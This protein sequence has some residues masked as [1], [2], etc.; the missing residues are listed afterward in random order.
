LSLASA[1][2]LGCA[3]DPIERTNEE[4]TPSADTT[5]QARAQ[6]QSPTTLG[7]GVT[8]YTVAGQQYQAPAVLRLQADPDGRITLSA[9][10]LQGSRMMSLRALLPTSA[11]KAAGTRIALRSEVG[12]DTQLMIIEGTLPDV[13]VLMSIDGTLNIVRLSEKAVQLDFDAGLSARPDG[14]TERLVS[15]GTLSGSLQIVCMQYAG[16]DSNGGIEKGEGQLI[17]SDD[18]RTSPQCQSMLKLLDPS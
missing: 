14:T 1:L 18:A 4:T 16:P 6:L 13:K 9:S 15:Q 11:V 10:S 7:A 8:E 3:T 2:L 12:Q 17:S 5:P